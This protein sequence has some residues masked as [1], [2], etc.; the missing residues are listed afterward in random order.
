VKTAIPCGWELTERLESIFGGFMEERI[1]NKVHLAEAA[2]FSSH[3]IYL[4]FFVPK[5][6][7]DGMGD[8]RAA[9]GTEKSTRRPFA[10]AY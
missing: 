9:D 7:L 2:V 3:D 1:F 6:H 8:E 4:S 5:N 10:S